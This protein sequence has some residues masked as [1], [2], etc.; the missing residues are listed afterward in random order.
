LLILH[1]AHYHKKLSNLA[2]E[3]YVLG[4]RNHFCTRVHLRSWSAPSHPNAAAISK[5]FIF[6]EFAAVMHCSCKGAKMTVM[7]MV[8][9]RMAFLTAFFRR[10]LRSENDPIRT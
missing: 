3:A 1:S 9:V 7:V 2:K 5:R 8:M 4:K 6:D 10:P